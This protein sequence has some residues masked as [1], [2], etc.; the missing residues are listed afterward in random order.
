MYIHRH[1]NSSSQKSKPFDVS[2]VV[3]KAGGYRSV[4]KVEMSNIMT[5]GE[6]APEPTHQPSSATLPVYSEAQAYHGPGSAEGP[7]SD[8]N[9]SPYDPPVQQP[10]P[11]LNF[12]KPFNNEQS[13]G[14][15]SR[16]TTP[17]DPHKFG[18]A[19]PYPGVENTAPYHY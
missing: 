4:E 11:T 6:S 3:P 13:A 15:Q 14:F 5:N 1:R 12:Q 8:M 17:Y 18:T 7:F 10:L 16:K 19:P 9:E 2:N